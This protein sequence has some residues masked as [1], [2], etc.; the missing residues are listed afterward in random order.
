MCGYRLMLGTRTHSLH[1]S[2]RCIHRLPFIANPRAR[3]EYIINPIRGQ[4][5]LIHADAWS[6]AKTCRPLSLACLPCLWRQG[7]PPNQLRSMPRDT[8]TVVGLAASLKRLCWLVWRGRWLPACSPAGLRIAPDA[9]HSPAVRAPGG[10][11]AAASCA[12][13][14]FIGGWR[15]GAALRD[16]GH[17]AHVG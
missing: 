8:S 7:T 4:T 2:F 13:R 14:S 10:A 1:Q 6:V 5:V 9:V 16:A 3:N 15:R 12:G 11:S 17:R